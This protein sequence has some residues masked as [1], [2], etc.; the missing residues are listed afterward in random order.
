MEI[1]TAIRDF[2]RANLLDW[3]SSNRTGTNWIFD[4][5]PRSDL[6]LTSYPRIGVLKVG[7]EG[8]TTLGCESKD[9]ITNTNIQ[10]S[11]FIPKDYGIEINGT[12]Y[13][14]EE[15]LTIQARE[16]SELMRRNWKELD[17]NVPRIIN[18]EKI[19]S[20]N[21]PFNEENQIYWYTLRYR[22]KSINGGLD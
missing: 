1:K 3:N 2:L 17:F 6:G 21:M 4:D 20:N 14:N 15:F 13:F 22:I 8:T 16:V 12:E 9:E 18:V 10:I 11:I 19:S 5:K 7:E